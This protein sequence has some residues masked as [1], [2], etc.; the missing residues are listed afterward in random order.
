MRQNVADAL[1]LWAWLVSAAAVLVASI[2]LGKLTSWWFA[3]VTG[4][5]IGSALAFI[6]LLVAYMRARHPGETMREQLQEFGRRL[7]GRQR[8]NKSATAGTAKFRIYGSGYAEV[9]LG[10]QPDLGLQEQIDRLADYIR[11]HI[12][13]NF[14]QIFGRLDQIKIDIEKA[15]DEAAAKADEAYRKAKADIDALRNE[16]DQGAALDLRWA[17]FGLYVATIGVALSYCVP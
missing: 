14:K 10:D 7:V 11:G 3:S 6:G 1:K 8:D 16:L 5:V 12:M 2:A 15:K 17:I 4:Q 13:P 9:G